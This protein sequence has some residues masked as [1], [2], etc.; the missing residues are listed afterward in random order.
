MAFAYEA[1]A[2]HDYP[3]K[4]GIII[5]SL[6]D[7]R[8]IT[9]EKMALDLDVAISTLSRIENDK[10]TPSFDLLERISRYLGIPI[11]EIFRAAEGHPISMEKRAKLSPV[12]EYTSESLLLMKKIQGVPPR[13]VR[14]LAEIADVINKELGSTTESKK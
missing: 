5:Q 8:G 3:M 13:N 12:L 7:D 6:R 2:A 9:L 10:R 1:K 4:I 11:S 14:L